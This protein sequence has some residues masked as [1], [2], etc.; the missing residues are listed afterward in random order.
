VR[1][2]LNI[3]TTFILILLLFSTPLNA[4]TDRYQFSTPAAQQRFDHLLLQLR[5]LVCQNQ[6]LADSNAPL[7]EDLRHQV[8]EM[9]EKGQSDEVITDFL[10]KRYGEFV[11]FE[12]PFNQT[13]YL[14]WFGP[15]V[16]LVLGALLLF[17]FIYK[18]RN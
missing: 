9:I 3:F 7:A 6:T 1:I 4:A 13:T 2:I 11:L 16:L 18:R 5:C 10:V 15:F 17:C 8:Y 12:P 14:L